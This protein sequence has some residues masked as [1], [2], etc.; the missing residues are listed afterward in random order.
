MTKTFALLAA[1]LL[2]TPL[3]AAPIDGTW[4]AD[5]KTAQLST[6]PKLRTLDHG[7]YRCSSCVPAYSIA[8]DGKFHP[9]KGDP[10][11][12]E[13]SVKVVDAHTVTFDSRQGGHDVGSSTSV[14]SPD[15]KTIHWAWKNI[16]KNGVVT[17]G[18]GSDVRIAPGPKGAHLISGSWRSSK[19]GK[20][21]AAGLTVTFKS[22]GGMFHMAAPTGENYDAK[23]GGP[24][25]P[26]KGDTG[27]T[28]ARVRQTSPTTWVETDLRKGKVVGTFTMRVVNPT[29]L[30]LV[31]VD[32]EAGRTTRYTA[33]KK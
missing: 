11:V 9:L 15:G 5:V 27:G 7:I 10:Y 14:V 24:A 1:S 29:T 28:M 20:I 4:V 8:A 12:D 6:K 13:Q 25:V 16:A 3:L 17:N 30:S 32:A 23:L 19:I 33:H 31:S 26:I 22:E 2:S 18:E 21:D